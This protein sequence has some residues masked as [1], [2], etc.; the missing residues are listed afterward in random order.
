MVFSY[1]E[2][3]MSQPHEILVQRVARLGKLSEEDLE[4]VR[5]LPIEQ[6][7]LSANLDI[8]RLGDKPSHSVLVVSGF[9][10][11]SKYTLQGMRQI[12]YFHRPGDMPDL[13]SL[14][15]TTLDATLSTVTA[16][17]VGFLRHDNLRLLCERHPR[18][19]TALWRS[20]LIDASIARE[21]VTNLGQRKALARMAHLFCEEYVRSD[22][23]GL[24]ERGG[25][26]ACPLPIT[27]AELG[28]ALGLSTVHTNRTLQELR[29]ADL[30]SFDHKRLEILNWEKLVQVAG[31]DPTYLHLDDEVAARYAA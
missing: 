9:A 12:H 27:Q 16:C 13:Y 10:A 22:V 18:V 21:W 6:A 28:E 25:A 11:T 1:L 8:A 7:D 24:R 20:T 19:G 14:H 29:E 26:K 15:L 30:V 31:F 23:A 17:T 4:A 5:S 2:T 3:V